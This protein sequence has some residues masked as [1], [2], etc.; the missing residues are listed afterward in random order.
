MKQWNYNHERL[1]NFMDLKQI[2][3]KWKIRLY[4]KMLFL[5]KFDLMWNSALN[6]KLYPNYNNSSEKETQLKIN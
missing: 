2:A 3:C 1:L 4:S 5:I 6:E